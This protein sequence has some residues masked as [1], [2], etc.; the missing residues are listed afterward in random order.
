MGVF[1]AVFPLILAV[2]PVGS[3]IVRALWA[4]FWLGVGA[5]AI[6]RAAQMSVTADASG[7]V[8]RN[9]GRHYSV[10]W[11][12]VASID[13]GGSDNVSG[14]VTTIVIRRADGSTLIGRGA[15]SY[16]QRAVERWRDALVAVQRR[17]A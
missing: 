15:S 9:F 2:A 14:A 17:H 1:I 16:S 11:R 7:L 4:A 12:D 5:F 8:V 13:A 3:G 10:P 6:G